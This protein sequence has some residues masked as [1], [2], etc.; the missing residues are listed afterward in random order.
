MNTKRVQILAEKYIEGTAT[1]EEEAELTIWY[2]QSNEQQMEWLVE[3]D[4]VRL[5]MLT[6]IG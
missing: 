5:R 4:T 1:P 6:N 3:K 2:R